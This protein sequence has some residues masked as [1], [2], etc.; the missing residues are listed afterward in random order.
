MRENTFSHSGREGQ[1]EAMLG[2]NEKKEEESTDGE[3]EV[4][5]KGRQK[6]G[7]RR[8]SGAGWRYF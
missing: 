6:A 7:S 8:W 5:R 2:R 1:R 3:G 4:D